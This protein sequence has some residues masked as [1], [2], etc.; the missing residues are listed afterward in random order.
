ME[1][2]INFPDYTAENQERDAQKYLEKQ[3][4]DV[5]VVKTKGIYGVYFPTTKIPLSSHSEHGESFTEFVSDVKEFCEEILNIKPKFHCVLNKG[6]ED[7]IL[8][9]MI[10]KKL[11]EK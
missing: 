10:T 8:Q 5:Y 6:I 11:I 9:Q 7:H 4:K 2:R 3:K 1:Q